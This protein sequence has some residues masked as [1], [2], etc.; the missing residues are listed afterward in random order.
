MSDEITR[1][2]RKHGKTNA[3]GKAIVYIWTEAQA[4]KPGMIE[5]RKDGTPLD[6][7]LVVPD[8]NAEG[9]DPEAMARL[10]KREADLNKLEEELKVIQAQLQEWEDGLKKRED[11]LKT[12]GVQEPVI[13][14]GGGDDDDDETSD[15]VISEEDAQKEHERQVKALSIML[16][17]HDITDDAFFKGGNNR[18]PMAEAWDESEMLDFPVTK[19]LCNEAWTVAKAAKK[20]AEKE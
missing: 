8:M 11:D 14:D 18:V 7:A 17:N 2:I 10:N 19:A 1:Y 20:A 5:C 13:P 16:K 12:Q 9:A 6:G 15:D 3:E 4:E